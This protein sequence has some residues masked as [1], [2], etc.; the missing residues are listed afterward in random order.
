MTEIIQLVSA[1]VLL[2]SVGVL[3]WQAREFTRQTRI[4]N[5]VA[6]ANAQLASTERMNEV[7]GIFVQYPELR[8]YFYGGRTP[9]NDETSQQ[10]LETIADMLAD[11]VETSLDIAHRLPSFSYNLSDWEDYAQF[12]L[13]NGPVF[14]SW[15]DQHP[16]WFP[17][18]ARLSA[19]SN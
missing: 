15:I 12:M 6:G 5:Q 13:T 2:L 4:A 16:H 18:L 8:P 10:R 17:T 1:A 7:L 19:Q 14:R 9:S 3:A 11:V